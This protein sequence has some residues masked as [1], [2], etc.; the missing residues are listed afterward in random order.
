MKWEAHVEKVFLRPEAEGDLEDGGDDAG[1]GDN[2]RDQRTKK[3][4]TA[5]K[6]SDE[7]HEKSII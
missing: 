6:K 1:V 3:N 4:K 5:I 7:F 2:C